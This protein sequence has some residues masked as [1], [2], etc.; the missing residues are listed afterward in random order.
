MKS[1]AVE[2]GKT[3]RQV[4]IAW[5]LTNPAVT[6]P[7]LGARTLAQLEDNLG[8]LQLELGANH[9]ARLDEISAV[10]LGFP[11]AFLPEAMQFVHTGARIAART[12]R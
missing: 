3:P 12:E 5:T 10:D 2:L 7:I 8:A 9:L 6:A 4:A 11:G 1:V